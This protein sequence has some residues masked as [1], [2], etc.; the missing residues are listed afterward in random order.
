MCIRYSVFHD[1]LVHW[2][3]EVK[4]WI[5]LEDWTEGKDLYPGYLGPV[6]IPDE[7][8]GRRIEVC[9]WGL[10]PWWPK[11]KSG[12]PD[13]N[14]GKRNAYNARS[15]TVYSKPTF[16]EPIKR[17]R[18]IVPVSAIYERA[19]RWVRILPATREVLTVAALYEPPNDLSDRTTYTLVTTEPNECVG[20]VHDRMPVILAERD[21]DLW[22]DLATPPDV[23]RALMTPCPDEWL[24]V[25]DGGPIVPPRKPTEGTEPLF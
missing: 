25:E 12:A 22:M 9:R 1:A 24:R 18:C 20:N 19:D 11:L 3:R 7:M 8:H 17:R 10:Q 6:L 4:A 15:E 2:S 13:G 21:V 14:W 5:P 23:L 16:R